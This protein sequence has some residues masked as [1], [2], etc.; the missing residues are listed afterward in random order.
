MWIIYKKSLNYKVSKKHGKE[1][2]S[3][4]VKMSLFSVFDEDFVN[5]GVLKLSSQE[6]NRIH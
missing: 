2:N 5:D 3:Y 4:I 1:I 6:Q